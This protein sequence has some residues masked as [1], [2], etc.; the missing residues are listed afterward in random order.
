MANKKS[1]YIYVEPSSY[2]SEDM[3]RA[4]EEWERENSEAERKKNEKKTEN[5]KDKKS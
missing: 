2:F 4:A 3:L 5:E 1:K